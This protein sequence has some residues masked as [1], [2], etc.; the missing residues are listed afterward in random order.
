MNNSIK[1][2]SEILSGPLG[3]LIASIGRGVGEA[4]AALDEGSLR[5]TLE[6]YKIE[7]QQDIEGQEGA[8]SDE[9]AV[10]INEERRLMQLIRSI[11]YQPTFYVIPETEVE[12][13]VSLNMDIS[14][15]QSTN[16]QQPYQRSKYRANVT[17][18]N[19]N[20][21]N[22]YNLNANAAATLKFKI[23]PVPAPSGVAEKRIM[24][25]LIDREYNEVT[26]EHIE[27]IGLNYKLDE[28]SGSLLEA[29]PSSILSIEKQNIDA[30]KIIELDTEILLTLKI[31][32]LEL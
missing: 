29:N 19:A 17:P 9:E 4:Q 18:L 7:S 5:Q 16:L 28:V 25:N 22:Q 27:S 26:R 32:E 31:L 1:Q 6:L 24:P 15:N 13:K 2:F 30:N 23:V 20:N 10:I 12:A 8:T 11:G 3:E 21:I 14:N